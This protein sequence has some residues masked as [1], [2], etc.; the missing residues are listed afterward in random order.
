M[1]TTYRLLAVDD[2]PDIQRTNKKYLESRGYRVDTAACASEALELL[3]D[4]SYDCILLDVLLPDLSGFELCAAVGGAGGGRRHDFLGG[5]GRGGQEGGGVGG[6][7]AW[8][9]RGTRWRA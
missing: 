8:T 3:H 6:G 4:N 5:V 7:A 2:E 9:T 1:T